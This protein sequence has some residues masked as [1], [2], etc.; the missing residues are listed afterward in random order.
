MNLNEIDPAALRIESALG[1]QPIPT[2]EP[3]IAQV[4]NAVTQS[5][6]DACTNYK[7]VKDDHGQIIK[8]QTGDRYPR[9][10]RLISMIAPLEGNTRYNPDEARIAWFDSKH[11]IRKLRAVYRAEGDNLAVEILDEISA[12]RHRVIK[13]DA[14]M[15][16]KQQHIQKIS[17][18]ERKVTVDRLGGRRSMMQRL[19]GK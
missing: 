16:H 12:I 14:L 9:I 17:G 13:G 19:T 18:A 11:R 3:V 6:I 5:L 1:I 2:G 10:K 7:Y 4:D 15:G 8:I